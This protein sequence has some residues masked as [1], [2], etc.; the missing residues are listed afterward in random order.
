KIGGGSLTLT[1]ASPYAGILAVGGAAST[2]ALN[3]GGTLRLQGEG[4]LPMLASAAVNSGSELVLDNTAANRGNRLANVGVTLAG[5]TL[6]MFGSGSAASGETLGGLT[7][8]ANAG[9]VVEVTPGAGQTA[10]LTF[11]G[12]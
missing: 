8:P 6:T 3:V 7:L 5:G 2:P 12:P 11:N 9:A 4:A 1:A 10:A